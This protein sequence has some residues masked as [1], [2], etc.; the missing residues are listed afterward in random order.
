MRNASC[1]PGGM[2]WADA[3][4]EISRPT[5]APAGSRSGDLFL[6]RQIRMRE[7]EDHVRDC[8]HRPQARQHQAGQ[9]LSA[10]RT[11]TRGSAVFDGAPDK[12]GEAKR[13]RKHPDEHPERAAE[14][15]RYGSPAENDGKAPSPRSVT[16][17]VI[18]V[19]HPLI[20][21]A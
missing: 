4:E 5:A 11:L 16:S 1:L 15:E 2:S 19:G 3:S 8:R 9:G 21:A 12:S 10:A 14:P 17:R 20:K 7:H 6:Y 13:Q 18:S